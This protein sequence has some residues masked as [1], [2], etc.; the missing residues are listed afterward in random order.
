MYGRQMSRLRLR[1][2]R[3]QNVHFPLSEKMVYTSTIMG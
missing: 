3:T 2:M 1:N